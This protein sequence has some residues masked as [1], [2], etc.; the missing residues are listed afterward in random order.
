MGLFK[1]IHDG[2]GIDRRKVSDSVKASMR[3]VKNQRDRLRKS[4]RVRKI[5]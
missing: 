2:L 3:S 5:R 4:E 1:L